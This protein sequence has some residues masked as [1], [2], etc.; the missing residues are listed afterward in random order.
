MLQADEFGNTYC[1]T[2]S[3]GEIGISVN[4]EYAKSEGMDH[5]TEVA[6]VRMCKEHRKKGNFEREL[7]G[8][9]INEGSL[10]KDKSFLNDCF[11]VSGERVCHENAEDE[12]WVFS[13]IEIRSGVNGAKEKFKNLI[14]EIKIPKYREVDPDKGWADVLANDRL[15][16]PQQWDCQVYY[17]RHFMN[18]FAEKGRSVIT[19]QLFDVL[20]IEKIINVTMFVTN[21]FKKK[22]LK[23]HLHNIIESAAIGDLRKIVSKEGMYRNGGVFPGTKVIGR[24]ASP[25]GKYTGFLLLRKDGTWSVTNLQYEGTRYDTMSFVINDKGDI[26]DK[27][28]REILWSRNYEHMIQMGHL[29]KRAISII[30]KY[31]AK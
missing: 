3:N 11:T 31:K 2:V 22:K 18:I 24:I 25:D 28:T 8:K 7:I 26:Q 12:T 16:D 6:Y 1:L 14:V 29:V 19:Q 10:E 30:N 9:T 4:D 20:P 23:N 5:L 13:N 21:L 27:M 15:E 17:K